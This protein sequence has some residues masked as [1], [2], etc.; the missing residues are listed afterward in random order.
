[1]FSRSLSE[2]RHR[3]S[4]EKSLSTLPAD[5]ESGG[6]MRRQLIHGGLVAVEL[7]ET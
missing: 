7:K 6:S 5:P 3:R 4:P 2:S 1:M